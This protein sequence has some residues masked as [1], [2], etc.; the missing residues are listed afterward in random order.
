MAP[1]GIRREDSMVSSAQCQRFKSTPGNADLRPPPSPPVCNLDHTESDTFSY[2][3]D[4]AHN[5]QIVDITFDEGVVGNIVVNVN[6]DPSVR[7]IAITRT[8]RFNSLEIDQ[9]YRGSGYASAPRSSMAFT[10]YHYL[11]YTR[12]ERQSILYEKHQCAGVDLVITVPKLYPFERL[13][14]KSNYKGNIEIQ[15][16]EVE[17]LNVKVAHGNIYIRDTFAAVSTLDAPAGAIDAQVTI[18]TRLRTSSGEDTTI[19]FYGAIPYWVELE[20]ISEKNLTVIYNGEGAFSMSSTTRPR[21]SKYQENVMNITNEDKHTLEGFIG[22]KDFWFT[23]LPRLTMTG[24]DTNLY[25]LVPRG[26]ARV[27]GSSKIKTHGISPG[28]RSRVAV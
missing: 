24:H 15:S 4:A 10:A 13:D 18:D 21:L 23:G 5:F 20:S 9:A 7:D 17:T 1:L 28:K 2:S 26:Q 3:L 25:L 11:D 6:D 8:L 19:E 22:V 16:I 14:L 12:R 27:D